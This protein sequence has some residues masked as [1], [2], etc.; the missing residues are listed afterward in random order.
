MQCA[1]AHPAADQLQN[2]GLSRWVPLHGCGDFGLE[3]SYVFRS[4]MTAGNVL[5]KSCLTGK[6]SDTDH[7]TVEAVKKT[8]AVYKKLRPYMIGDFYPLF[9]HDESASQWYG[10][11]FD[12]PDLKAGC[13]ILFRREKC[14]DASKTI[15]LK[16]VNPGQSYEA[17]NLD[18]GTSTRISGKDL[19]EKGLAVEIKDKPSA[20]IIT[21]Q[22]DPKRP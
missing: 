15:R 18:T 22:G 21:Y 8:V 9:P 17:T 11:Q 2:G 3:P 19:L 6:A 12:N 5:V 13:A 4:A 16:G 7:N 14:R 10:Y 20:V 1:G